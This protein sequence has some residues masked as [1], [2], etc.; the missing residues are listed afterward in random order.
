VARLATITHNQPLTNGQPQ[1]WPRIQQPS[2]N[3]RGGYSDSPSSGASPGSA[4][5]V[6]VHENAALRSEISQLRSSLQEYKSKFG[7]L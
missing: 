5:E 7:K 2:S 1:P 3:Q 4:L 6:L